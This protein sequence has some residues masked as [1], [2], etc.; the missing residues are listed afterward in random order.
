MAKSNQKHLLVIRLS[1]MGDVAMTVP[2]LVA[3]TQK[4]P[5]LRITVLTKSFYKPILEQIANVNVHIVDVNGKH[6]GVLGL[7]KL[8]RELIKIKIDAVADLHNVLRSSILKQ[9][10]RLGG[11]SVVQIEKGRKEKIALTTRTDKVFKPLK[12]THQRYADVFDQLGYP[13][14]LENHKLPKVP[15]TVE[16][17]EKLKIGTLKCIGVAP[18]A[19]FAGKTYPL[20]LMEEVLKELTTL[21]T[22][23]ILLFGGGERE[24]LQLEKWEK[25][26]AN[27]IVVAGKITFPDELKLISNL[28]LMLSMDSGNAHLAAMYGVPTI[29]LWGV[30][31]PYAGFFPYQQEHNT[32]VSDR[33]QFPLIP[34]SVYGNKFP[35][36]YEKV[37][38]TITPDQVVH[39]IRQVLQEID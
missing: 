9:F 8:Y 38:E 15:L 28:E 34:T 36:G 29:T 10:F 26:F 1:A 19:A 4:Y 37:M 25:Q 24:K 14:A 21:N 27:C 32:M 17:K 11:I 2:V 23:R 20:Q 35:S 33:E 7:W 3:L 16:V 13:V 18:F 39:K 30:T 12:T 6:K 5:E 22:Y 31:H